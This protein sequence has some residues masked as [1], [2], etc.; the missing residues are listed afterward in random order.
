MAH[1]STTG[2]TRST[3]THNHSQ[4]GARA[5][6]SAPRVIRQDGTEARPRVIDLELPQDQN[7]GATLAAGLLGYVGSLAVGT[8]MLGVL[9]ATMM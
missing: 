9:A 7:S 6:V 8:M 2:S 1:F 3:H 4:T 5:A